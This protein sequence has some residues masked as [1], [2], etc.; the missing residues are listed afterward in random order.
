MEG[1]FE[2][3]KFQ[4]NVPLTVALRFA[5]GK[6]V[7]SQ[8]NGEDQVMFTC[9]D[10]RRMYLSPYAAAKIEALHA[11]AGERITITKKEV[12]RGNRRGIEWEA[13]RA[14]SEPEP[15]RQPQPTTRIAASPAAPPNQAP[16]ASTATDNAI[17][18]KSKLEFAL[19]TAIHAAHEGE[20]FAHSIGY[21]AYP[22][23]TSEDI[24]ALA[25][26]VLINHYKEQH[27]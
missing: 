6:P 18:A 10:G 4:T 24:R 16:A 1:Q 12:Q 27:R 5:D 9:S 21:S 17:S 8:F 11:K 7:Q 20:K 14:V 23:F 25:C 3:I 13:I 26:T 15:V 19:K 22:R 2:N